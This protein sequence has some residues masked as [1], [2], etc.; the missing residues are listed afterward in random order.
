MDASIKPE[1]T[2]RHSS[3]IVTRQITDETWL[4]PI[5]GQLANFEQI[6]HLNE[7]GAF[8]WQRLDGETSLQTIHQHIVDSY[9]VDADEAWSD[10]HEQINELT[11]IGIIEVAA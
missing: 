9:E 8:I 5:S 11:S 10:L 4:I 7:V 1:T 3:T 6:F 2:Y